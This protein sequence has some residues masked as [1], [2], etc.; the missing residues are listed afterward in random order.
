MR[1]CVLISSYR[2]HK[3]YLDKFLYTIQRLTPNNIPI[4]IVISRDEEGE[5]HYMT[6]KYKNVNLLV[7]SKILEMLDDKKIIENDLLKEYGKYNYQSLKKYYGI[8]YLFFTDQYDNIIVFDSESIVIRNV[9]IN[10]IVDTYV[11]DP[12]LI[13]SESNISKRVTFECKHVH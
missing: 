9:D 3:C 5:F 13:Y 1:N 2:Q 7:F 4:Y 8:Y 6:N 12:A 10:N 11:K